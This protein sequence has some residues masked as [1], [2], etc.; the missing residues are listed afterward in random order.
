ML[1]APFQL[2]DW[3]MACQ[4]KGDQLRMSAALREAM[5]RLL[6]RKTLSHKS[7]QTT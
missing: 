2:L 3:L 4:G 6:Q 5:F 1:T 7:H